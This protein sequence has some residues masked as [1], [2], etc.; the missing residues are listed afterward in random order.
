ML[1]NRKIV[2]GARFPVAGTAGTSGIAASFPTLEQRDQRSAAGSRPRPAQ[3]CCRWS[4]AISKL[5]CKASFYGT[6]CVCMGRHADHGID[7]D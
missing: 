5:L 4:R 2:R 7:E 1:E 3:A 6:T